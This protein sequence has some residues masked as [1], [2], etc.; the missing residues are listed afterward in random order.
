MSGQH[1]RAGKT[2]PGRAQSPCMTTNT[3]HGLVLSSSSFR[4]LHAACF[5]AYGSE[6]DEARASTLTSRRELL[7]PS[8]TTLTT[9]RP[10]YNAPVEWPGALLQHALAQ[11]SLILPSPSFLRR[12]DGQLV[13]SLG[14]V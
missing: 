11:K 4:V 1:S 7:L 9:E 5:T 10:S 14:V 13:A 6:F 3:H 12:V 2:D 8:E